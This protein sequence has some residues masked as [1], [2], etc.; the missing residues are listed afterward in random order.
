MVLPAAVEGEA[1][2]HCEPDRIEV[3]RTQVVLP[4]SGDPEVDPGTLAA[5]DVPIS[6]SMGL[7]T[8]TIVVS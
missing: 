2:T 5:G 3:P 6:C 8:G 4:E 7:Y 1:H